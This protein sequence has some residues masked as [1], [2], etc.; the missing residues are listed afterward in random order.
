MAE[1]DRLR[2]LSQK[3]WREQNG[4]GGDSY[5]GQSQMPRENQCMFP[6]ER[7]RYKSIL[8][9]VLIASLSAKVCS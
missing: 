3:F 8:F 7:I 5:A 4:G 9:K 6:S 1:R 2:N